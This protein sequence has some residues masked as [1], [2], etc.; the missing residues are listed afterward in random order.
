MKILSTRSP[1]DAPALAL[2][3]RRYAPGLDVEQWVA[4]ILAEVKTR[5]DAALVDLALKFDRV[6]LTPETFLVGPAEIE[7]DPA[8]TASHANVLAFAKC[9]LR[10]DWQMTNA[11]GAEVGEIY[12]PF[13]RVG[14]Y[15]PGGGAPLVSTVLMTATLAQAPGLRNRRHRSVAR[16]ERDH[17]ALR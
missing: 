1:A 16:T 11:Q 9:G 5:G 7:A 13:S 14:I 6:E 10:Q 8:L 4:G 2:L 12:Q 15:V 17:G 3:N